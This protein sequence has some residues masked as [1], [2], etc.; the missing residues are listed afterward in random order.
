[1]PGLARN[2]SWK[3]CVEE[4]KESQV[5]GTFMQQLLLVSNRCLV[6]KRRSFR[7]M[8]LHSSF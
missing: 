1:M 3:P 7:K 5:N 4:E 6:S 8:Y 2:S